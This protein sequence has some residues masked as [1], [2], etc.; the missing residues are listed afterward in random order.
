VKLILNIVLPKH[1]L[2]PYFLLFLIKEIKKIFEISDKLNKQISSTRF[3]G[4]D[5]VT[6]T[7]STI[8]P[9]ETN[10]QLFLFLK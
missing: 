7:T 2:E 10:F 5:D 9:K 8:P 3:F 1:A 6:C 4:N